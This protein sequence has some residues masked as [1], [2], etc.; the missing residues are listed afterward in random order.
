MSPPLHTR[1]QAPFWQD[2][3]E[4]QA[5]PQLP[6]LFG[7]KLVSTHLPLQSVEPPVQE[8]WQLPAEHT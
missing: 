5:L 1:P 3:P 4:G 8:S 2:W 7:S 6:Q